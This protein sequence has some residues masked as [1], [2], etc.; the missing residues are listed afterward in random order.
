MKKQVKCVH[1]LAALLSGSAS[2]VTCRLCHQR[3]H[4]PPSLRPV[5]PS[6][7]LT[8]AVGAFLKY[9]TD[10]GDSGAQLNPRV[11]LS[12]ILAMSDEWH[13]LKPKPEE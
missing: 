3:L 8:D 4:L 1:P 7:T 5:L 6:K 12:L 13:A 11:E 10:C 2:S 9:I